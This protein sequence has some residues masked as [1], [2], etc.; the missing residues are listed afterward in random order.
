MAERIIQK[1]AEHYQQHCSADTTDASLALAEGQLD[2]HC[3]KDED[4]GND[5]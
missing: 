2:S 3:G 1:I 5:G 4:T